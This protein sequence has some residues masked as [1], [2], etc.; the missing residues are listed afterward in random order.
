MREDSAEFRRIHLARLHVYLGQ[1]RPHDL[2]I[3]LAVAAKPDIAQA[4][5]PAGLVMGLT[6]TTTPP[7]AVMAEIPAGASVEI[8]PGAQLTFLH[9]GRCKL[10]TVSGGTLS[11][12]RTEFATDG[13][14]LSEKDGPC[15]RIHSLAESPAGT[16]SGG[17]VMRGGGALPRW[18]LDLTIIVAGNGSDGLK[19]AAIYAE[20]KNDS[21]LVPL[22]VAGHTLRFPAGHERLTANGRYVLRLTVADRSEPIELPFIGVAPDGPE[23]IVVLRRP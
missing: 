2:V 18:P 4:E 13:Q 10:I 6:G 3:G 1:I 9:Y 15:P 19:T 21:A 5:P 16:V 11:L 17:M 7:L 23:L 14:I 22:D 20:D 12:G 8:A